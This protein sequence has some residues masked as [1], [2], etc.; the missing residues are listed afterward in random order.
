[1]KKEGQKGLTLSFWRKPLKLWPKKWPKK[2]KKKICEKGSWEESERKA[3]NCLK[4]LI[5]FLYILKIQNLI[6]Q[7]V[8]GRNRNLLKRNREGIEETRDLSWKLNF[9]LPFLIGQKISSIGRILKK[10]KF[11]KIWKFFSIELFENLFLW[12]EMYVHDFKCFTKLN[13]SKTNLTNF[14][15][16]FFSHSPKMH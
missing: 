5:W 8:S 16:L 11:W 1:M 3:K 2:K 6:G 10:D 13:F 14:F 9:S 7:K 15:N 12:Y 4:N